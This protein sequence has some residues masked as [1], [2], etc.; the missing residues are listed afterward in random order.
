M[1]SPAGYGLPSGGLRGGADI[2]SDDII[3]YKIKLLRDRGRGV[4]GKRVL[5]EKYL[6]AELTNEHFSPPGKLSR[7][8]FLHE[9]FLG[10]YIKNAKKEEQ[11]KLRKIVDNSM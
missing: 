6:F 1:I 2:M 4:V 7:Q 10:L 3:S 5:T 8:F 9:F 11:K